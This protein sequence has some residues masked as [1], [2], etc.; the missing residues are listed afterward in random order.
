MWKKPQR[1]AVS[2]T[3]SPGAAMPLEQRVDT[4][5]AAPRRPVVGVR[6]MAERAMRRRLGSR[7]GGR[8]ERPVHDLVHAPERRPQHQAQSQPPERGAGA[9]RPARSAF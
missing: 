1:A 8:R 5:M 6:L 9:H 2:C 7:G 4:G 3:V